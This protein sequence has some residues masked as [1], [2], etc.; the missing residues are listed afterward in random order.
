M[1][2][3]KKN[4][5]TVVETEFALKL[6]TEEAETL[7]AVLVKISGSLVD[8]P[9]QHTDSILKGLQKAGARDWESNGHP[10]WLLDKSQHGVYFNNYGTEPRK[11]NG[12]NGIRF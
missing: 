7:T 8:S 11:A 2:E 5:R 3:A 4:T 1:A 12:F 10:Y 9:R 6:S